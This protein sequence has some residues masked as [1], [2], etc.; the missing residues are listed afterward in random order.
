MLTKK[1][2]FRFKRYKKIFKQKRKNKQ[3]LD[4]FTKGRYY[5]ITYFM[6]SQNMGIESFNRK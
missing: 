3:M 5:I 4:I 2:P 1:N 6:S